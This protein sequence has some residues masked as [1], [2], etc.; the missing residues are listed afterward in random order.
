MRIFTKYYKRLRVTFIRTA[1]FIAFINILFLPNYV[2]YEPDG[3]NLFHISLN[4]KIVGTCGS[5]TDIEQLLWDARRAVAAESEDMVYVETSLSIRGEEALFAT[6]D[7]DE[8]LREKMETII[9]ESS[10]NTLKAGYT[11]KIKDYTINLASSDEVKQVLQAALDLYEENRRYTVDLVM[12]PTR[13]LNALT[14][15]V[16]DNADV[17]EPETEPFPDAGF[18]AHV[19]DALATVAADDGEVDFSDF[20]YGLIDLSYGD[21]IE[22]VETICNNGS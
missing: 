1:I 17:K 9:K 22:V 16:V 10:R 15:I 14:A 3:E 12:D 7:S 6:I 11:I 4:D 5:N 18:E 20:E 19:E 2:P 13:E 8:F 21:S